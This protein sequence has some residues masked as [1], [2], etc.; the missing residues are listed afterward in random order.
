MCFFNKENAVNNNTHTILYSERK[1]KKW[2]I[3]AWR[4]EH[5]ALSTL[6]KLVSFK[7]KMYMRIIT[8]ISAVLMTVA[9]IFSVSA[10]KVRYEAF[11]AVTA[12]VL[13]GTSNDECWIQG[14]W[15]LIDQQWFTDRNMPDS[16]DFYGRYKAVWT[17]EKLYLLLEITDDVLLD[18]ITDPLAEYWED[19]C[20]E[21]FIDEDM[22]GGDHKCC[23]Q[24]YNAFAYHT[25]PV[26]LDA[27]DLSDDG[28]FVPKLYN[29]NLDIAVH[30]TGNL[31]TVEL[32]I[33]LYDDTFNED[34][35]NNPVA[36]AANKQL[37][38]SI[39]YCDDDGNGREDFLATQAGG[40]DSWMNA[41]LFGELLLVD[42]PVTGSKD[43]KVTVI[44]PNPANGRLIIQGNI[45]ANQNYEII[46]QEG[47]I[48]KTIES[49][50]QRQE[51]EISLEGMAKGTYFLMKAG[52]Q[53]EPA[54]KFIIL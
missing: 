4:L 47:K 11:K 29:D 33:F 15:S 50:M 9:A 16:A 2:S 10:Q 34:T 42:S 52:N 35:D 19:D 53:K 54:F 44:Y 20:I 24:A 17:A 32:A 39:A 3:Q 1:G 46:D 12:P 22:S 48:V 49:D 14:N 8:T 41:D 18:D 36:L 7:T 5:L 40:L 43:H 27:V 6:M 21:I 13:D 31:I 51:Q 28:D 25:S 26:T 38:F 23:S 45:S 37:G 30:S